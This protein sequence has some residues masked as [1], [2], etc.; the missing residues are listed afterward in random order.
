MATSIEILG[1]DEL[2]LILG[3]L[4]WK[5]ILKARVNQ[6]WRDAVKMTLVPISRNAD[7][8]SSQEE[9]GVFTQETQPEFFIKYIDHAEA[10]SWICNA[11][12]MLQCIHCNFTLQ[13]PAI[14]IQANMAKY[15]MPI[16]P[17][18]LDPISK[19]QHLRHLTL[20]GVTYLN[21]HYDFFTAYP[22]LRT[23]DLSH[24][25]KVRMDLS[26]L[27]GLPKLEK[28]VCCESTEVTGDIKSLRVIINSLC[29]I[30]FA[31]C[32]RVGG[33]LMTLADFPKL[34]QIDLAGTKVTGDIR[35]IGPNDFS[36]IQE[37]E[38]CD[39]IYGGGDLMKIEDAP[40]I[41]LAR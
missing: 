14:I 33:S 15:Y 11:L 1:T 12:P 5:D 29:E 23:L 22:E 35:D 7:S 17:P 2:S 13:E 34:Q 38:L 18:S 10:L 24:T 41:M 28:L 25:S 32:E 16:P 20:R 8:Y 30:D 21:A 26:M 6:K 36:S 9:E 3:F 40:E 37:M 4:H 39:T 19:F 27:S 31:G